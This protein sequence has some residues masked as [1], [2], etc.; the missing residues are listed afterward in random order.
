MADDVC[1][2]LVDAAAPGRR[3]RTRGLT[4]LVRTGT[5]ARSSWMWSHDVLPASAMPLI[6]AALHPMHGTLPPES[7]P[8]F[9]DDDPWRRTDPEALASLER[10]L[11]E[12]PPI[13]AG[14]EPM[15]TG[16]LA[17]PELEVE[18]VEAQE[19]EVRASDEFGRGMYAA[20]P[21]AAGRLLLRETATVACLHREARPTHCAHCLAALGGGDDGCGAPRC[22]VGYGDR[23]CSA[24]CRAAA[25]RADHAFL[26][27][28]RHAVAAPTTARL[29]VAS[30]LRT[31]PTDR[32]AARGALHSHADGLP[33]SRAS[34]LRLHV[35]LCWA[36]YAAPLAELAVSEA[37]VLHQLRVLQTNTF[38]IPRGGG[39]TSDAAERL[40]EGIFPRA[41]MLNH[42]CEP[43]TNLYRR[44]R[45][46]ELR[47]ARDLVRGEQECNLGATSARHL[48]AT[49]A[50]PRRD[51]G[52]TSARH[53]GGRCSAATAL[54]SAR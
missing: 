2:L 54:S 40:G 19:I 1:C 20:A 50:R 25:A 33:A 32:A 24:G 13:A 21:V 6:E 15:G 7:R 51:L 48:G 3:L 37:G 16:E 34:L 46:I 43:N 53:L 4:T 36:A 10:W 31:R 12:P 9:G 14:P 42:S 35:R 29:C 8:L 22:A 28:A 5:P 38:A 41:A 39:G 26:C 18:A 27:A 17:G 52:A 44:G 49:S 45:L 23:H 30:L 11:A 47:A